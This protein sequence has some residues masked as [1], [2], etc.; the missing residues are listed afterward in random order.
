M[1]PRLIAASLLSACFLAAQGQS[2]AP[3]LLALSKDLHA[4]PELSHHEE[5]T[6]AIVADALRKDGYT[7][8]DHVGIYPD[9]SHAFG[10]VGILKNGTGPTLL[11]RADMDALPI[12]EDLKACPLSREEIAFRLSE[13]AGRHITGVMVDAWVSTT[14]ANRFPAELIPAWTAVLGSKRLIEMLV[15]EM[16]GLSLCRLEDLEFAELGRARLR[17]EKLAQGL[18]EKI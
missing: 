13:R 14:K 7:V 6:S 17:A 2:L 8:I 10:V 18:W 15:A 9:G 4:H 1:H 11:I 5:R 12:V 3:D 16:D